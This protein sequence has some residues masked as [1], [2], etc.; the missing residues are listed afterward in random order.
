MGHALAD[1]LNVTPWEALLGEV[2]R[3]A[4]EVA[5]LDEKVATAS[6][7]EDLAPG[8]DLFY[9]DQKR[10]RMRTHL[11]KVSA[12]AIANGVAEK[13][14]AQTQTDARELAERLLRVARLTAELLGRPLDDDTLAQVRGMIRLELL[15][16]GPRP[17]E[18]EVV[19]DGDRGDQDPAS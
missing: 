19:S 9:W 3:S 15:G 5:W 13:L 17:I 18:G 14:V 10:E 6:C 8:G 1:G 16:G 11:M 7:D 12:V 2:R 4:G